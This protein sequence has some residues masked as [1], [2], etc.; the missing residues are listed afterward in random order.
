MKR[1][2]PKRG[3]AFPRRDPTDTDR[4]RQLAREAFN[5][6]QR[7]Y[8]VTCLGRGETDLAGK[9]TEAISALSRARNRLL[10]DRAA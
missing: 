3:R 8:R 9:L 1:G 4:L 6:A 10:L 2:Q 7:V 5:A